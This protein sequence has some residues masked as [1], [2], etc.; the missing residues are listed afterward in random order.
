MGCFAAILGLI[1]ISMNQFAIDKAGFTRFMLSPIGIGELVLG[2]AV[3][4][5]LIAAGPM[6][7]CF[8][9]PSLILPGGSAL[10]WLALGLAVVA[11]FVLLAPA[12]A[13]LS[14]L[15]PKA[16]DL[17]SIGNSSNAHQGA[18]LLGMLAFVLSAAPSALLAF[19]AIG[20]LHRPELAPLFLLAWCALAF[21]ISYLLFIP[22]RRLVASRCETLAG[23]SRP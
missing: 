3:G 16:V 17:N 4:N 7:F 13:A 8:V 10:L 20:W 5:A 19:L 21:A 6:L 14:A 1:P 18:T 9:L 15:F 2:K 23:Y 11:T 22:V 12:A